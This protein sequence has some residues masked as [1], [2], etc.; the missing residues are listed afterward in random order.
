MH[1]KLGKYPQALTLEENKQKGIIETLVMWALLTLIFVFIIF[2]GFLEITTGPTPSS[3]LQILLITA[4][5]YFVI[6]V[7]YLHQVKKWALIYFGFS[8]PLPNSLAPI[9][10][11]VL[12]FAFAGALPLSNSNFIPAPVFMII[13]ALIQPAFYEEFFFR[14]VVQGNLERVLGQNKAWIYGGILFGLTPVIPNYFV[15]GFDLFSGFI[16]FL[17]QTIAGWRARTVDKS[18]P[19]SSGALFFAS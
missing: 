19:V 13:V 11:S 16:Q 3:M 12:I 6:P 8:K 17:S 5:F 2:S 14:G 9:L 15:S 10:F 4:P 1:Y 18:T 7:L